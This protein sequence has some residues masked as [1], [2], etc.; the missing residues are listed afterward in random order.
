M[1]LFKNITKI[2]KNFYICVYTIA[3]TIGLLLGLFWNGF[4]NPSAEQI[5]NCAFDMMIA[6]GLEM[7]SRL[8]VK[9]C[10]CVLVELG[11]QQKV[12]M[13]ENNDKATKG[14][15]NKCFGTEL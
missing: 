14:I 9:T 4:A 3:I 2:M 12:W 15:I 1:K 13:G 7:P 5:E 6:S 8:A 11:K 10:H